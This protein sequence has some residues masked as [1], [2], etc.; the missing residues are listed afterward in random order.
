MKLTPKQRKEWVAA[1]PPVMLLTEPHQCEG[2]V[3]R[4]SFT[5]GKITCKKPAYWK[6]RFDKRNP[7]YGWNQISIIGTKYFCW[8]HLS[9][10]GFQGDM[11]E[12]IKFQK[13]CDKNN[14]PERLLEDSK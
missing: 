1:Y 10:R 13:W 5:R 4:A 6:F 11:Y 7:Y 2:W 9:S 14:Y 3:N 12:D 8:S